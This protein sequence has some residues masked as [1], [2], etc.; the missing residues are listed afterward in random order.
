MKLDNSTRLL[1]AR[2]DSATNRKRATWRSV[3]PAN[4]LVPL[5]AENST[6]EWATKQGLALRYGVSVRC[7]DNWVLQKRIPSVKLGRI[8]RFRISRCDDALARFE[9]K[10]AT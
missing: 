7:I 2:K 10:E 4:S 3:A 5:A 8:I 9:R 1:S 6:R